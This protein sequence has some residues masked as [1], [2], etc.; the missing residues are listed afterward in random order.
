MLTIN[1]IFKIFPAWP[2]RRRYGVCKSVAKW[3]AKRY[4]AEFED[5]LQEAV[6][7]IL[8]EEKLLARNPKLLQGDSFK[9]YWRAIKKPLEKK[10]RPP[11]VQLNKNRRPVAFFPLQEEILAEKEAEKERARRQKEIVNGLLRHIDK[12]QYSVL[13]SIFG[14]ALNNEG[15]R[16][17]KSNGGFLLSGNA[18][19]EISSSSG[20]SFRRIRSLL[21]SFTT[22]AAN[23]WNN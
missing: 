13:T 17:S 6:L 10:F 11:R 14:K 3:I 18:I 8:D 19:K 20:Y 4:N 15:V 23:Q 5:V 2:W 12:E 22:E 21:N 9:Y 1:Y 16:F 7:I